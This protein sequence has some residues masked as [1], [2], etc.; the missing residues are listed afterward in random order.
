MCTGPPYEEGGGAL[1]SVPR[2]FNNS[3]VIVMATGPSL[4]QA[5]V[6]ACR[7]YPVIAINN[8]YEY[9]P[10]AM[11]LY[12]ADRK[13]WEC[14]WNAGALPGGPGAKTFKGLKVTTESVFDASIRRIESDGVRGFSPDPRFVRTGKNSAYQ[15]AHIAVHLGG[16]PVLLLGCD[17]RRPEAGPTHFFGDHPRRIQSWSP[18]DSWIGYWRTLADALRP[19]AVE[20]INCTP[21][22]AID[23]F[24]RMTLKEAL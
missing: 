1:W 18:Y 22:S 13:W 3:P 24:P 16:N 4:T 5:Q 7:D 17:C 8:A 21:G 2:L 12:A 9:A 15:G 14:Y 6:D 19:R 20:I 10:W 23:A 11:M